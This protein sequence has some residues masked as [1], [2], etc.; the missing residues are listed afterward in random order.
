MVD[1]LFDALAAGAEPAATPDG[2][3]RAEAWMRG[4]AASG[5]LPGGVIGEETREAAAAVVDSWAGATRAQRRRVAAQL[6]RG[7]GVRAYS[8]WQRC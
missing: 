4:L 8:S 6:T 7:A 3:A 1:P 2:R 5:R